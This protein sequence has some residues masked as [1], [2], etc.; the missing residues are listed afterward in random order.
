MIL[1][2]T[3][4]YKYLLTKRCKDKFYFGD[5]TIRALIMNLKFNSPCICSFVPGAV[6]AIPL[7]N[8][9]F[10]IFSYFA[11][12][13]KDYIYLSTHNCSDFLDIIYCESVGACAGVIYQYRKKKRWGTF[14]KIIIISYFYDH[15]LGYPKQQ[16]KIFLTIFAVIKVNESWCKQREATTLGL[17]LGEIYLKKY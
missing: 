7:F 2:G 12:F 10:F 15:D 14:F 17:P 11:V 8:S 16:K 13:V 4:K 1:F 6:T 9:P 3:P 5:W